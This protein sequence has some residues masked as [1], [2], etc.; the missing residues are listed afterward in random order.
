MLV[1]TKTGD[2]RATSWPLRAGLLIGSLLLGLTIAEIAVRMKGWSPP[3]EPTPIGEPI[4]YIK[5]KDDPALGFLNR[6]GVS[7]IAYRTRADAEPT[8]VTA[9]VNDDLFRGKQLPRKKPDGCV[10]IACLGDSYT[11]GF[12]VGDDQTWP[13]RLAE[14]LNRDLPQPRFETINAGVN[15]Y[16]TRQEVALLHRRVL[17]FDP[18]VVLIAFFLND[19]AIHSAGDGGFEFGKPPASYSFLKGNPAWQKLRAASRLADVLSDRLLRIQY[20]R[21][22]GESRGRLYQADAP[23]WSICRQELLAARDLCRR[24]ALK[25]SVILYPLLFRVGDRLATHDAYATV[26]AFLDQAEIPYLDLEPT[27]LSQDVDRLRVHPCD[28]HPNANAHG[29]AASAIRD[30]LTGKIL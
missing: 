27:F 14:E 19:A 28:A 13:H 26:A 20:L 3:V 22:L 11:F 21:F 29:L 15:N 5:V 25:L 4:G 24:R 10:R 16:D 1:A 6:P 18:D 7:K 2:R 9:T 12:G 8:L 17:A 23:G 30:Y